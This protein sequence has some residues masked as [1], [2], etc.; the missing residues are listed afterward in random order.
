MPVFNLQLK[1]DEKGALVAARK[2]GDVANAASEV[3]SAMKQTEKKAEACGQSISSAM[4]EAA[5]KVLALVS[6][7]KALNMAQKGFT[8]GSGYNE[9][10][11][12][13]Q[14]GIASVVAAT[15]QLRDTQGKI[16]QGQ[17]KFNAAQEMSVKMAKALDVASMQSPA[18][19]ED[20]LSTLQT[21]LA[22][23]SQLG[24]KWQDTLDITIRMSNVLSS[25]GLDMKSLA[26]ETQAILTGKD[27]SRS[28]V[29]SRLGITKEEIESWGK[30]EKL[31]AN[32]EKRFESFK[33]AGAAV[34]NTMEAVRAYYEDVLSN[35]AGDAVSDLWQHA[36][37][38]MQEV[39]DAFYE[40]D[41]RSKEFKITDEMKPLIDATNELANAL[42]ENFVSAVRSGIDVLKSLGQ[43]ISETGV[44]QFLGEV[45]TY[46]GLAVAGL[47]ALMIARR[48]ASAQWAVEVAGTKDGIAALYQHTA[49]AIR[50]ANAR[51]EDAQAAVRETQ[52]EINLIK[53]KLRLVELLQQNARNARVLAGARQQQIALTN[54]L[55]AAEA[56][57]VETRKLVNRTSIEMT[58]LASAGKGL[59]SLFGGPF[60][61]ALTALGAGIGYLATRQTHAEEAA[62]LHADALRNLAKAEEE[63]KKEGKSLAD[64][65]DRL[66]EVEKARAKE[67]FVATVNETRQELNKGSFFVEAMP[68]PVK[69]GHIKIG[70]L[71]EESR[72]LIELGKN[73]DELKRKAANGQLSIN[74]F[75]KALDEAFLELSN[76]GKGQTALANAINRTVVNIEKGIDAENRLQD[77]TLGQA[78]ASN[79]AGAQI[80]AQAVATKELTDAIDLLMIAQQGEISSAKEALEYLEKR[81]ATTEAGKAAL[82]ANARSKDENALATLNL[83]IAELQA[84]YDAANA[85]AILDGA[86]EAQIANAQ[87]LGKELEFLK[88]RAAEFL[89]NKGNFKL[90]GSG[91]RGKGGKGKST[92][93]N[94]EDDW[95]E[96]Q[97]QLAQLEGKSTSTATSLEKTQKKIEDTGKAAKK[98]AED[99]Q[100][101]KDAFQKATDAKTLKE[102]NKELLQLEGNT[103]AVENA[104][105]QEKLDQF[106]TKLAEIKSLSPEGKNILLGRYERAV[107][108][109]VKINDTQTALD[110]MKEL[111]S[112]GGQYADT[113][114]LQNELIEYQAQMY[115]EKL[116]SDMQ[117]YVDQWERLKKLQNDTSFMGGL[118][119][120]IARFG[121]DYGD[122]ASTVEGFTTQMGSTISS[123]LSNAFTQGKF[124]AQDFFQS[125][126]SMAAQAASNYFIGML[127]SGMAGMFGGGAN[128]SAGQKATM[129]ANGMQTG[130]GGWLTGVHGHAHG[131]VFT[132]L[133]GFSN[134]IVEGPTLFGYGSHLT[135]YAHGAGL[136]GERGP[137]AVMPLDRT[138]SGDLGVRVMYEQPHE[139]ASVIYGRMIAEMNEALREERQNSGNMPVVN[140]N[141]QNSA[142]NTDVQAGQMRPDGNG[143]FTLDVMVMQVEQAMVGHMKQ[144][145]S[146]IAQYQERAYGMSRAGVIARGRG[147]N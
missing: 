109:E 142:P 102:L 96:L 76:A 116:P 82:E 48:A 17:E 115:R 21:M 44:S 6:A 30:G 117:G 77:I 12:K 35:L 143:G 74:D 43:S 42:G 58:A 147:R 91:S 68:T 9:K 104:E 99:I 41:E 133:S 23:A 124:S 10:I 85:I 120:G 145:K 26:S 37:Q 110:F 136:M 92:T 66:G 56:R 7:W 79:E 123:T 61:L 11:E 19:Y 75:K 141:I 113:L 5:K 16:L 25:L 89:K 146:P 24:L 22:P 20:L 119:R 87:K 8:L 50:N 129:S 140:V 73:L 27:I 51:H 107:Q 62:N 134:Q 33:Y 60:G 94:P 81:N 86:T 15:N 57:L 108:K 103:R 69:R 111:E 90:P 112:L 101:M 100:K 52:A 59:L 144:G 70:D 127:F 93:K 65:L 63:A 139:N 28:S 39:A 29:A 4:T 132:G 71:S 47:G 118:Q 98:S 83:G 128:Y 97:A 106:R 72:G 55:A 126:V 121:A 49:T 67:K 88:G 40:I 80:D 14:L 45:K 78:D 31:L 122:L 130:Y 34:E 135:A 1:F 64:E 138:K 114:R 13:A 54:Q 105:K 38:G 32:L 53:T 137:E 95:K 131:D 18:E 46:A 36:K 125:L 3:T 84:A 2:L